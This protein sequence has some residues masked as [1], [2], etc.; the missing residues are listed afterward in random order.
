MTISEHEAQCAVIEWCRWKQARYP[1][2][3]FIFAVPNGAKLPYKKSAGGKRYS[4][5]AI[6][7]LKE[8]LLPGVPDLFLPVP[9][10]GKHG[11]FIEMKVGK[12]KPSEEQL[13]FIQFVGSLGYEAIVCFGSD[14]AVE[15]IADYLEIP[16][17]D[18]W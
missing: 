18:R 14:A 4:P 9:M 17:N 16:A 10:N 8:G 12:N 2:L 15:A 1:V 6:K 5:Q 7:L 13:D 11:L 3:S